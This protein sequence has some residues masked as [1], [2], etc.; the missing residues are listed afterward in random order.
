MPYAFLGM[1]VLMVLVFIHLGTAVLDKLAIA[2][3]S[4]SQQSEDCPQAPG[5]YW[6]FSDVGN[7]IPPPTDHAA[8]FVPKNSAAPALCLFVQ[9]A[10]VE[11]GVRLL[12]RSPEGSVLS[13]N[14]L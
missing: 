3:Q 1:N 2:S 13:C 5:D 6:Q 7:C 8:R 4:F 11:T 10:Q 14:Y 12:I 9:R